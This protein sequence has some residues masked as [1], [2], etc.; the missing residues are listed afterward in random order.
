[1]MVYLFRKFSKSKEKN[2]IF[3]WAGTGSICL[4]ESDTAA[5]V[6]DE[7]WVEGVEGLFKGPEGGIGV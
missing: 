7:E 3:T 1:M 5:K 4:P 2:N 6:A